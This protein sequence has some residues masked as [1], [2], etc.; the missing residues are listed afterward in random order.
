MSRFLALA[1]IAVAQAAPAPPRPTFE[2]ASV[3]RAPADEMRRG[4]RGGPGG[5]LE[6]YNMT[7]RMLVSI[8]YESGTR[9][10][11]AQYIGSPKWIDEE[12]FNI[13][14]K[15]EGDPGF[16]ANRTPTR[17]QAML[18][19][20]LEERFKVRVHTE[21]RNADIFVLVVANKDGKLGPQLTPYSSECYTAP[22]PPG[23][24]VDP[25]R[26][27]GLGNAVA[28]GAIRGTGVTMGQLATAFSQAPAVGGRVVVDRTDL[29]GKYNLQLEYAPSVIPGPNT[30]P[31]P[32]ADSKPN[33]FTAIQEQLGLKL[34]SENAPI[35]FLVV[36]GAERPTED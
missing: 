32:A 14:A 4:A 27:C 11:D 21:K 7:L 36:D 17:Y 22:P 20:L 35:E 5:R 13:I 19:S 34:Q 8:A 33:V 25:A 3:K 2:T 18:R 23:T 24:P 16:D 29:T 1:L 9:P 15:A 6:Y 10:T 28:I 30:A 12:R 26:R 31:N